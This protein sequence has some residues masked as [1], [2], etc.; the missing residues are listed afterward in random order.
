MNGVILAGLLPLS[1]A[2]AEMNFDSDSGNTTV[3]VFGAG[4]AVFAAV[5]GLIYAYYRNKGKKY[6][7]ITETRVRVANMQTREVKINAIRGSSNPQING[8]NS[9]DPED[10]VRRFELP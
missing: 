2:T 6:R 9:N 1:V 10:R 4:A 7:F 8:R 3:T 5:Y